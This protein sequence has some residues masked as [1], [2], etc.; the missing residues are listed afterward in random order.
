[1]KHVYTIWVGGV[2]IN[3]YY[4]SEQ[5]AQDLAELWRANGY[6]DVEIEVTKCVV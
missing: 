1:M 3:D 5:M 2:E 6:E 4:L